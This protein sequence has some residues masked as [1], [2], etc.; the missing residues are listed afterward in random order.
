MPVAANGVP[1]RRHE[2]A[3]GVRSERLA[4]APANAPA[5]AVAQAEAMAADHLPRTQEVERLGRIVRWL[6][7]LV[8]VPGTRF[9]IGLDA[10][11]GALVPGLGDAVTGAASLTLLVAAARRGLPRVVLARM[12]LNVTIDMVLG[13]V[14]VV[15]D[16]FDL[17]WRSNVRN[18]AL[19]ERHQHELEPQARAGDWA[20][21]GAAG[22]VVAL[23][24][25]IPIAL[26]AWL[27]SLL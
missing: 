14:P 15:G 8:R 11:A 1:A 22:L 5:D 24:V 18:L 9:G 4:D 16:V 25:A 26:V 10:I 12:L 21:V 20:I 19:I 3:A 7:D 13:V 27:V 6:E 23:G 2:L 17:L